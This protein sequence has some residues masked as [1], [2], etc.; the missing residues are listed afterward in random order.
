MKT[1]YLIC[2]SD[3]IAAVE[4]RELFGT[5]PSVTQGENRT[6]RTTHQLMGRTLLDGTKSHHLC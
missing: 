1:D 3:P 2:L 6:K 5:I 4:M